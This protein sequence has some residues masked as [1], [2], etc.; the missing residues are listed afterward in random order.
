V[1]ILGSGFKAK[2]IAIKEIVDHSKCTSNEHDPD[3]NEDFCPDV[4]ENDNE[5][6]SGDV[7]ENELSHQSNLLEEPENDCKANHG[8]IGLH[9]ERLYSCAKSEALNVPS[10]NDQTKQ[11]TEIVAIRNLVEMPSNEQ[12]STTFGD[13]KNV[14]TE[15]S[16]KSTK[17]KEE[18]NMPAVFC[19][20]SPKA[21][22]ICVVEDS[23]NTTV[24][25]KQLS[26]IIS[27]KEW[28]TVRI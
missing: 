10:V 8:G 11:T 13:A 4:L 5:D 17:A 19:T 20:I 24:R 12:K 16:E 6:C 14:F 27:W 9:E 21:A 18:Q 2:M 28:S 23:S 1:C 26:G 25:N 15:Q 7:S 22:K 3:H